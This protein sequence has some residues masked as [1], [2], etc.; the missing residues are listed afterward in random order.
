M[1]GDGSKFD[2]WL[3]RAAGRVW[4]TSKPDGEG[5]AKARGGEGNA[6]DVPPESTAAR[7][8]AAIRRLV[9]R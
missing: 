6:G 1:A 9:R 8:N 3:R 5:P 7:I 2:A 4:A